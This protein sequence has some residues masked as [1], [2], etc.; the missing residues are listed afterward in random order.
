MRIETNSE[1][2]KFGNISRILTGSFQDVSQGNLHLNRKIPTIIDA[3]IPLPQVTSDFDRQ[4]RDV[5]PDI[6]ADE[7]M[8]D[9]AHNKPG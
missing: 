9:S 1:F 4:P 8:T 6:G 2:Q 5:K 3:A 7:L